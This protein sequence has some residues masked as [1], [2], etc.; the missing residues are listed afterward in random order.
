MPYIGATVTGNENIREYLKS[1]RTKLNFNEVVLEQAEKLELV[2]S[3]FSD[4]G[5]D[6]NSWRIYDQSAEKIA[7]ITLDG[8]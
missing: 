6:W 8:Y 7:E 2:H 3:S 5:N 4:P 1:E